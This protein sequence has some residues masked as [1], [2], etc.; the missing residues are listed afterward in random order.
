MR[1][2]T[3]AFPDVDALLRELH[4]TISWEPPFLAL[5]FLEESAF[6]LQ[7]RGLLI[8]GHDSCWPRPRVQL[9]DVG[10]HGPAS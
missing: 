10:A 1:A 6:R 5:S 8:S 7:G 4:P 9:N 2:K 3:P